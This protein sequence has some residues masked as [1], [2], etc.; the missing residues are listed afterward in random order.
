MTKV[1]NF[2]SMNK[3]HKVPSSEET[4]LYDQ[5]T[6][7]ETSIIEKVTHL[8]KERPHFDCKHFQNPR[9]PC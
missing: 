8:K 1:I 9:H 3:K 4:E 2:F 6:K 5:I 7:I